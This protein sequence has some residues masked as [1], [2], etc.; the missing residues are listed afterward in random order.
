MN[1][2]CHIVFFCTCRLHSHQVTQNVGKINTKPTKYF[3]YTVQSEMIY[4]LYS[5]IFVIIVMLS[6]L[7]N[8]GMC[9]RSG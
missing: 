6:T 3:S 5:R 1:L 9:L 2:T 7:Q 4:T 8:G